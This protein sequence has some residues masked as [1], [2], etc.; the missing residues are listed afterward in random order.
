MSARLSGRSS[1]WVM[2]GGLVVALALLAGAPAVA[3]AAG[4]V[5]AG[6]PCAD[7]SHCPPARS[8]VLTAPGSGYVLDGWG[9]VHNFGL[10]PALGVVPLWPNWDIARTLLT[11]PVG[12]GGYIL[13]G[14][15]AVHPFAGAPGVATTAYWPN[16]DIARGA[17]IGRL[18]GYVLDGYGALHPFGGAPTAGTTAYWQDWDIARGVVLRADGRSGYVLDGF[19][20]LHPFGGAPVLARDPT[21]YV[22][23]DNFAKG[24]ALRADGAGG[25]VVDEYGVLHP[26]GNAP[27]VRI[28]RYT[29]GTD[30]ARAIAVA[31][32]GTGYVLFSDGGLA[33]FTPVQTAGSKPDSDGD[34]IPDAVD[35]CPGINPHGA[36]P[37]H[38]GCP[39]A[40][41]TAR[42][43]SPV[44]YYFTV[45]AGHTKVRSLTVKR[46]PLGGTVAVRCHG[47]GCPFAR[48]VP[49]LHGKHAI[50]LAPL[51]HAAKLRV[52]AQ[53]E[54]RITLPGA[55]GKVMRFA[56]HRRTPPKVTPLCLNPTGT[57]PRRHCAA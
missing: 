1:F 57:K 42:V 32:D 33:S 45:K 15:G 27:P 17:A 34:G 26:F 4:P 37:N 44:T 25:Y 41:V 20:G 5:V 21:G 19:G 22:S 46:I 31:S 14:W 56:I 47:R 24:A 51:F 35:R 16:W 50:A 49:A 28:T 8:L 12:T 38:D 9:G 3:R 39:D 13:D 36:D 43:H 53:I 7:A 30:A 54:V 23:K 48:A 55:I 18:G 10:A 40:T 11:R 2:A 6:Y 29:A 52:G